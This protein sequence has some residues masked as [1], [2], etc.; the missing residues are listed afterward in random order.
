MQLGP[1]KKKWRITRLSPDYRDEERIGVLIEGADF[2]L[3]SPADPTQEVIVYKDAFDV[4]EKIKLN[5]PTTSQRSSSSTTSKGN[6]RCMPRARSIGFRAACISIAR[7]A[8]FSSTPACRTDAPS[9]RMRPP[10]S[11]KN[12]SISRKE[13]TRHDINKLW[14]FRR[15]SAV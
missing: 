4:K 7:C 11:G 9:R 10:A 15:R 2:Y 5:C 13:G 8:A 12:G 6:I 14:Q 3:F 1:P